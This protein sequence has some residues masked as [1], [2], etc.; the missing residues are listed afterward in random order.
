MFTIVVATRHSKSK[1]FTDTATGKSL[2]SYCDRG[3]EVILFTENKFGLPF[4]YNQ[5]IRDCR[6]KPRDLIFIHDDIHLLDIFWLDRLK[7]GLEHFDIIGLAGNKRRLPDQPSWAFIDDRFTWDSIENL[8][9]TVAH[10]KEFPPR[11]IS[12]FGPSGQKVKL[13]D[14]LL[15]A[16]KSK[17]LI[18]NDLLF[19]EIFDFH[20]YDLDFC[21]QAE[22]R[23][24]TCGTWPISVMHESGGSFGSQS[25]LNGY[26]RYIKK[27]SGNHTSAK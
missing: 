26:E 6:E 4:V 17:T 1:F 13:L 9:G 10:G 2:V 21:R 7:D 11:N 23:S 5:V 8:S 14:G 24:L 18:D 19:D 22:V 3:I 27:W 15:I 25:W 16:V 12:H 20:F